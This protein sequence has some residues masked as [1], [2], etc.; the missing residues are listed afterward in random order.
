MSRLRSAVVL[1]TFISVFSWSADAKALAMPATSPA[2]AATASASNPGSPASP[3]AA[4]DCVGC[5]ATAT[6][7]I[8]EQ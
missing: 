7:G 4:L 3:S 5:H 6:P 8:V 1:I 2:P